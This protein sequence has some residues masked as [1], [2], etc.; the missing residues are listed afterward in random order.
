MYYV[1]SALTIG[2]H[3]FLFL[4]RLLKAQL[5]QL[6]PRWELGLGLGKNVIVSDFWNFRFLEQKC[7]RI[8]AHC[9]GA[10]FMVLVPSQLYSF[11]AICKLAMKVIHSFM[12]FIYFAPWLVHRIRAAPS[13]NQ[14]E[15]LNQQCHGLNM[16]VILAIMYTT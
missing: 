11:G 13:T 12:G 9:N 8:E 15:G 3:G 5:T 1:L 14:T 2:V 16:K 6:V 7:Y 4:R 10:L